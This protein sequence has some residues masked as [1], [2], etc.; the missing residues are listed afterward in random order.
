M[1]VVVGIAVGLVTTL[2]EPSVADADLNE[3]RIYTDVG[4][5]S[6]TTCQHTKSGLDC[7]APASNC[8]ILDVPWTDPATGQTYGP[9]LQPDQPAVTS[10]TKVA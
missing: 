7:P 1:L 8:L 3:L 2:V 9:G 10:A 5:T 4:P 6:C